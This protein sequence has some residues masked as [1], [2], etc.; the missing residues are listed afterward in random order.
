MFQR[1]VEPFEGTFR[2]RDGACFQ[3]LEWGEPATARFRVFVLHGM[4]SSAWEFAVLGEHLARAGGHVLA[5]HQRGNGF[6]PDPSRRGHAF[7][8][9]I[10]RRDFL[11]WIVAVAP[12]ISKN[13][14]PNFLLGESLGA[15][16]TVRHFSH[17]PIRERFAGAILMS[18]VISLVNPPPA[19]VVVL[20]NAVAKIFPRLVIPTS[21]FIHGKSE[22]P[23]LTRDPEYENH[24]LTSPYRVPAFTISFTT[25]VGRVMDAAKTAARRFDAPFLLLCG[26]KDVF[27]REDVLR[28]WFAE[29]GSPDK[30]FV[31]YPDSF[32]LLLHDLDSLLVLSR[33][34]N[35]I[36][37]R[38]PS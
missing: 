35:W 23:P 17:R 21:L 22:P 7:R 19:P 31:S 11:D 2:A 34:E 12:R 10:H 6:D 4:G 5:L 9:E 32:H 13:R 33:I 36:L 26:G 24:V 29:A 16:L 25:E 8:E 18:P 14:V 37:Q 20:L 30:T 27:V 38:T 1:A 28:S 15:L 3:W